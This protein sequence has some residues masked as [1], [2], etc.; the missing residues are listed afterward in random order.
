IERGIYYLKEISPP[1]GYEISE[2]VYTVYAEPHGGFEIWEGIARES[3][4]LS[5]ITNKKIP[6]TPPPTPPPITPSPDEPSPSPT[7]EESPA[8]SDEPTAEPS[9]EPTPT[10][11]P[12]S[13]PPPTPSAQPAPPPQLIENIPPNVT[14]VPGDDGV[15]IEIGDDG[16]PRGEWHYDEGDGVWV[17]E[18]YTPLAPPQ[19]GDAGVAVWLAFFAGAGTLAVAAAAIRRGMKRKD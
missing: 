14:L 4:V 16:T 9:V 6:T 7:P 8:P 5:D 10:P 12:D 18:E 15:W 1:T 13:T 17:F 11:T 2:K 3:N 19:T